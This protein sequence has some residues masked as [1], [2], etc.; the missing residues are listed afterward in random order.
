MK[1]L[2]VKWRTCHTSKIICD[3]K[4]PLS[5]NELHLPNN[6]S[7]SNTAK[8]FNLYLLLLLKILLWSVLHVQAKICLLLT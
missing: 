2:T 8:W 5:K 3:R 1:A 7:W 6:G 4:Q